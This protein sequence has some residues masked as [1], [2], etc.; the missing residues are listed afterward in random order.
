MFGVGLSQC[1]TFDEPAHSVYIDDRGHIRY[2]D[3]HSTIGLV[4]EQTFLGQ[5]T[6]S[7]AQGIARNIQAFTQ[8]SL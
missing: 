6:E 3:E 4:L 7:F 2:G 5:H 1:L 8:R